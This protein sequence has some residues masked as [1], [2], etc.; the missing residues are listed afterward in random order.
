MDTQQQ[1][2]FIRYL[3][4]F[5]DLPCKENRFGT[6][7]VDDK[8]GNTIWKGTWDGNRDFDW[9]LNNLKSHFMDE[10]NGNR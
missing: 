10:G 7:Y 8:H 3:C 6:M 9:F 2:E 5:Y 1:K 4:D